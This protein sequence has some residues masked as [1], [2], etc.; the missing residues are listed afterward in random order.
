MLG[1]RLPET[2]SPDGPE[3]EQRQGW[4]S[5]PK[6]EEKLIHGARDRYGISD[7]GKAPS[8]Y[9]PTRVGTEPVRDGAAD[10][11]PYGRPD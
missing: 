2:S 7:D 9:A 11:E 10:C 8:A 6:T 5:E 3:L 4:L 1:E